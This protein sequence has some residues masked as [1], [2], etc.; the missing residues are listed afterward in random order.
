MSGKVQSTAAPTNTAAVEAPPVETSTKPPSMT[1]ASNEVALNEAAETPI[2]PTESSWILDLIGI[3][4]E[5]EGPKVTASKESTDN[6]GVLSTVSGWLGLGP[7]GPSVG[8]AGKSSWTGEN[9]EGA[10]VAEESTVSGSYDAKNGLAAAA[11]SSRNTEL[12]FDGQTV[13]TDASKKLSLA[14]GKASASLASGH[15]V[16]EGN[17]KKSQQQALTGHLDNKGEYGISMSGS[18]H[19][20]EDVMSVLSDGEIKDGGW[21]QTQDLASSMGYDSVKGFS[22]AV[23]GTQ[24]E[25]KTLDDGTAVVKSASAS[26]S[27]D[28]EKGLAASVAS[29][30]N[31]E[32]KLGDDWVRNTTNSK[33]LA[34]EG[35]K[36]SG[37]VA[38]SFS[39][40]DENQKKSQDQSLTGFM[41]DK[42]A[43]GVTLAGSSH[44]TEDVMKVLSDGEIKD[45][46]W[47]QT[48][49]LSS[50]MSYDSAKGFSA[51]V[52]AKQGETKTLDDGAASNK[53]TSVS[54]SYS[55]E[56]GLAAAVG[57]SETTELKLGDDWVRNTTNSKNLSLEGGKA[58][59][60]LASSFS[61]VDENQK[62]SQEQSLTGFMD[63]KGAYGV[64]LAGSSHKTEDVMKVL[65]DGEIKDGGWMQTQDLSSMMSYD[66]AKGFSAAVG[67]KQGETK[68]LDDGT[69]VERLASVS[70]SYSAEKGLAAAVGSSE[71]TVL[72]IDDDFVRT[73][74]SSKSLE[75]AEGKAS[76]A[77][78]STFDVKNGVDTRSEKTSATASLSDKGEYA[79]GFG[80]VQS[81][82]DDVSKKTQSV[83]VGFADG[84]FNANVQ[85]ERRVFVDDDHYISNTSG[86]GYKDGQAVVSLGTG[87]SHIDDAGAKNVTSSSNTVGIGEKGL[88]IGRTDT[89]TITN[90]DKSATAT[91]VGYTGNISEGQAGASYSVKKTDAEG[92]AT[93]SFGASGGIDLNSKGELEGLDGA[94]SAG[95]GDKNVVVKGAYKYALS[96]PKLVGKRWVVTVERSFA[97]GVAGSAGKGSIGLEGSDAHTEVRSFATQAEAEAFR[98]TGP[99]DVAGLPTAADLLKLSEGDKVGEASGYKGNVG[100]TAVIAGATASAGLA[101]GKTDSTEVV[102]GPGTTVVATVKS[103]SFDKANGSLGAAG[104]SLGGELEANSG[105]DVQVQFD[106]GTEAGKAA[107]E[108][109]RATGKVPPKDATV[110]AETE[111]EGSADSVKVAVGSASYARRSDVQ[112]ATTRTADGTKLETSTGTESVSVSAPLLG[113]YNTSSSLQAT[114]TNDK[115]RSFIATAA[116][117]TDEKGSASVDLAQATDTHWDAQNRNAKASGKWSVS[118]AFSEAQIDKVVQ[119]AQAGQFNYN[120]LS[121]SDAGDGKDLVTTLQTT[122]DPD[123]IRKALSTF[124][125]Q[126]GADGLALMRQVG[127]GSYQHDL[128]LEGDKYFTGAAGRKSIENTIER[129]RVGLTG[130]ATARGNALNEAAT[131]LAYLREKRDNV[132][133]PAKYQDLPPQLRATELSRVDSAIS[134]LNSLISSA[135]SG[136]AAPAPTNA[137]G[138]A[139]A[140]DATSHSKAA[141]SAPTNVAAAVDPKIGQV[142]SDL[143]K[144]EG[145]S[146]TT[147]ATRTDAEANYR[148]IRLSRWVHLDGAYSESPDPVFHYYGDTHWY[149]DGKFIG[150]YQQAESF[151]SIGKG[152]WERAETLRREAQNALD[153][154][155]IAAI[156]NPA[157]LA[158]T[159][160]SAVSA[161]FTAA[162]QFFRLAKSAFHLGE[163][164]Y[165]SIRRNVLKDPELKYNFF[166]GYSHDLPPGK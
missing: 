96:E 10:K 76:G 148:K 82:G 74:T 104:I 73:T 80:G 95:K 61:V 55:Q 7:D 110:L 68:T 89:Q 72:K 85:S 121:L 132:A 164:Q 47:M 13:K 114:E 44:K 27:Y 150:D 11:G 71:N 25:T 99:T 117:D 133:N 79:I 138:T 60:S 86:I 16:E 45:G 126:T 142:Q 119:T 166:G 131:T 21:M 155:R 112:N 31:T 157:S 125:A 151:F 135:R 152:H 141:K 58:S 8:A 163:E 102:R 46:G 165:Q 153:T 64:T 62:K 145:L 137:T 93:S 87:G 100:G 49:D 81:V 9:F 2:V 51:A 90:A 59:G 70:G 123:V 30:E 75:L 143:T 116:V 20:T 130:D 98:T 40:V 120:V 106:L 32:L 113:H 50:T 48:Q 154:A 14:G 118:T 34:L 17:Q 65:S 37:S 35:G 12:T 88:T 78:S 129:C 1:P 162:N 107:Y 19:K 41:D 124:V 52:G 43:Y 158:G 4:G 53:Q 42:G 144:A 159:I 69:A 161:K 97:G 18:S 57:S 83:D 115:S 36:A 39:V 105:R 101:K 26:G 140:G 109:F 77:L 6:L 33:N 134:S 5:A 56:K 108:S 111:R 160:E 22:A 149:G 15:S 127:G 63:D 92:K 136:T 128:A 67:G 38:S 23:S 156:R 94:L 91:G 28:K 122:K 29:S 84:K 147:E 66:S 54:G 24:G 103:T 3:G 139:A 146:A